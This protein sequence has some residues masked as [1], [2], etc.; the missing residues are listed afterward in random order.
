MVNAQPTTDRRTRPRVGD[1][2]AAE[3]AVLGAQKLNPFGDLHTLQ[4][5]SARLARGLRPVWETLLR[6]EVR[7]FAEPLS[8]QRFADYRAERGDLLTGWL[9][10][11]MT[12]GTAGGPTH[13]WL[14]IDGRFLIEMLDLFFGG[15]GVAP[16]PMPAEFSPAADAMAVRVAG[17]FADALGTAWEPLARVSFEAGRLEQAADIDGEDAV[18]VTRVG[19]DTTAKP[20]FVDILYPVLALKPHGATLTGK[21]VDKAEP[22][23]A[24]RNALARATMGVRFPVRSVLA[25][26]V[27]P[28]SMLMELKAGDVIPIAIA[29]DVPVMV[30]R[31]RLGCGTVGTSN[32]RA[33]IR[34]TSLAQPESDEGLNP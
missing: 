28:L 14:V 30:G 31:D 20:M 2:A 5:L 17:M 26:P 7:S 22:D 24:W 16:L 6:R 9:P 10:L 4:H 13:A 11:A 29:P 27:V 3:A 12:P 33:A 19:V 8:V 34:L 25:E 18:I 32:G 15:A 23:P 21:V 1:S